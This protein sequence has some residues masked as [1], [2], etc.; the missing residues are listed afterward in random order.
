MIKTKKV[1]VEIDQPI[2]YICDGCGKSIKAD[3]Y[4]SDF[5]EVHC[6]FGYPSDFDG[7]KW[8]GLLCDKCIKERLLCLSKKESYL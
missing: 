4:Y 7:E 3:E 2:E 1:S 8:S 6:T 5:A